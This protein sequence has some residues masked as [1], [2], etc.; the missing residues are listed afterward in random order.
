M[1]NA[2]LWNS[3][4]EMKSKIGELEVNLA[5]EIQRSLRY[6]ELLY[7]QDERGRGFLE[8]QEKLAGIADKLERIKSSVGTSSLAWK[9]AYEALEKIKR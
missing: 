4:D 7:D 5:S 2:F 9:L 3:H 1:S 6:K 8:I